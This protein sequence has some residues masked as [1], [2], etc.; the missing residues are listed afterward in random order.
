MQS[1]DRTMSC[2]YKDIE[3]IVVDNGSLD[4][5]SGMVNAVYPEVKLL[6]NT[7]N[8][9]FCKANNQGI[10]ETKGD[11][12]LC[13]NSDCVLDKDYLK[14]AL[15]SFNLDEKIG[16]VSGKILRMDKK[17][18]DSTGLFIARNRK[19]LERGYGKPDKGQYER[20]EYIFG[21]SGSCLLMK[22][23]MLDDIKDKNGYFD[24][25]FEI[26]YEDLDLCWRAQKKG[27]KAY[28]NPKAIAYHERGATAIVHPIR[29]RESPTA[30]HGVGGHEF[31]RISDELKK[32]YIRNR[33]KCM[34][35]NDSIAGFLVNLPFI[36]FYEI[37]L[38]SYLVLDSAFGLARTIFFERATEGSTE[39][40][41]CTKRV[42]K[43]KNFLDRNL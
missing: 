33:Y 7:E 32:R 28:Y 16:M 14:E 17:T 40:S 19:P 12:I 18:I 6:Q 42:E 30:A 15:S 3:I 10:K 2:P 8:L 21:V 41:E 23:D 37:K 35:K 34:R 1:R 4:A 13:L 43:K 31:R 11:F 38:C 29:L 27:W 9:F 39:R 5:S 36:L 20:P 26:Y 24:E 25:T 22:K